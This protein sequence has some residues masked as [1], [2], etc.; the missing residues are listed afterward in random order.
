MGTIGKGYDEDGCWWVKCEI[1]IHH[2]FSWNTVQEFGCVLNYM[3]INERLPTSFHPVS[4]PPYM[5]GGPEEYLSWI[6]ECNNSEFK[7]DTCVEWL[8]ARLPNPVE[9]LEQWSM[10]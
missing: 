4:P 9:N 6:I 2:Q 1:D 8:I 10:E 5:N 3:S 7:P